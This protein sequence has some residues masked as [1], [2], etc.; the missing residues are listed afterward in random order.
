MT[1][2]DNVTTGA[3]L[4]DCNPGVARAT[5]LDPKRWAASTRAS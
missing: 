3:F 2:L 5:R 4:R 1:V